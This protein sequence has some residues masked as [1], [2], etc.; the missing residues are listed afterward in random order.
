M[1]KPYRMIYS[2]RPAVV[3]GLPNMSTLEFQHT[4]YMPV[5]SPM[6][7]SLAVPGHLQW[8]LPALQA[9]LQYLHGHRCP[10]LFANWY[11]YLTVKRSWVEKG[12]TGNREGWHI[13]GYGSDGDWNFIW[14]DSVPT[15]WAK[16]TG[17]LPSDH[18]Q[19]LDTLSMMHESCAYKDAPLEPLKTHV[20]YDLGNTVHRCGIAEE[21]G[22]RTFVKV[23]VSK[24]RYD[25]EGNA[26]NPY[27]PD[28][29]WPLKP[30]H[31]TRNHPTTIN[32]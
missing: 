23:S 19:C 10:D 31:A 29:W 13:D 5:M 30:R 21:S 26:R 22:M 6:P 32:L 15:E 3:A 7:H 4:V 24:H 1:K 8:A 2:G 25:L 20:L 18:E 14:F 17:P 11:A 27:L 9:A 16:Y 12:T 28:T